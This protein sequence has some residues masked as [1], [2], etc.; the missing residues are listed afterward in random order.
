MRL[1]TRSRIALAFT[2][3]AA[4]IGGCMLFPAV[5][6]EDAS[7][8]SFVRQAVP[9]LHGRKIRGYDETKLLSDLVTA[10]DKATVLR[11][12]M[13][14]PEFIDNWSEV[15][16][17]DLHVQREGSQAQPGC[18]GNPMRATTDAGIAQTAE[19]HPPGTAAAGGSFNMSDM[20]RSALAMDNLYPLY[21][22]HLYA[23]ANTT[24][25]TGDEL[26]DRDILG[27]Q[28]G[29]MYLNRQD[30][31]LIC[32]NS[33]FSMSGQST[34][35]DRT[36]PILGLF[37]KSLFGASTG[38]PTRNAYAMFRSDA[39]SGG[40]LQ[41]WGVQSCGSFRTTLG[42]D[43]QGVTEYFVQSQGQQFGVHNLQGVLNTGYQSLKANGLQRHL[44]SSIQ[45]TC[46]FCQANCQGTTVSVE[47]AANNAPNAASVKSLLTGVCMGC[48]GGASNL[49]FTN[50]NDWANDLIG[51]ASAQ[52]A[53]ETLVIPGDANNSYLIK[54]LTLTGP[55]GI[56]AG[57]NRMPLGQAPLTAAQIN[58]IRAWINGMATQ[59]ACQVCGTVDCGQVPQDVDGEPAFAYLVAARIVNNVWQEVFGSYVTIANYFPRNFEQRQ[60]LWNLTE[61]N[62][63]PNDWSLRNL[64]VRMMTSDMFNRV[65]PRTTAHANAY[66]LPPV[67]DPWIVLDPRVSPVSDPG[68]DPAAHPADNKNAM[69][70]ESYR[71]SARSLTN[72][73][74]TAL[75]WPKP[76][77]FPTGTYPSSDLM[78]A[79]GMYFSDSQPGFQT[80]D[81][82]GLLAWE[83]VHGDCVNPNPANPDWVSKVMVAVNSWDAAANGGPLTV[84]DIS[85]TMRDWL[86]GYGGLGSTPP[87]GLAV[88]ERDSLAAHFGVATLSA[89]LSTVTGLEGKLRALCGKHLE[90]P[91]FQLAGIVEAGLGPKPRLRVCNDATCSYQQMCQAIKPAIDAQLSQGTLLCG[92]DSVNILRPIRP[93]NLTLAILCPPGICGV[94]GQLINQGCPIEN[95]GIQATGSF[96]ERLANGNLGGRCTPPPP[97]CDPRC[98]GIDCCGGPLP[99]DLRSGDVLVAWAEG[100]TVDSADK[101]SIQRKG[102]NAIV[103]LQSGMRVEAGDLIALPPGSR[104]ALRTREGKMLRTPDEGMP[105]RADKRPVVMLVSGESALR[106]REPNVPPPASPVPRE[107][108]LRIM[109]SPVHARGEGGQ[110]LTTERLQAYRYPEAEIKGSE[111]RKRELMQAQQSKR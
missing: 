108:I 99:T 87:Q 104:M 75:D 52:K 13:A 98:N 100:G 83:T 3:V 10:T 53:G 73:V 44:P 86:L 34:G 89:P 25:F 8:A 66:E 68:Y 102:A 15:L 19:A 56:A 22:A 39:H 11:A 51:V 9:I 5:T 70:E 50:G 1:T 18:Y 33:E 36:Y 16:V 35:W 94:L 109:S 55:P 62:F 67:F 110:I 58:M 95:V 81:F 45:A 59:G 37:E 88:S 21:R 6:P 41:P 103:P 7:N 24:P 85:I 105:E 31:C 71:Y 43:P 69:S 80:S 72:S 12:L 46:T 60:V 63:L 76:R 49:Y 91:Q 65:P 82:A 28:F 20:V 93:P 48:H 54:K 97:M 64:L 27:G 90:S 77:R 84:E 14:Q 101:A 30:G 23:H 92:T 106:T 29:E 40:A 38:E 17:D 61:Y 107:R 32:H 74:A 96:T 57:T 47:Q 4:S 78:R 26:Q 111:E 42:N 2:A 79:I